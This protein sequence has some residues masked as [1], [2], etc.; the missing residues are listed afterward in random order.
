MEEFR[1]LNNEIGEYLE[2]S[3]RKALKVLGYSVDNHRVFERGIDVLAVSKDEQII[4]AIECLNWCQWSYVNAERLRS[5]VN[6]FTKYPKAT[7]IL[8]SSFDVLTRRQKVTLKKLGILILELDEQLLS[9]EK[10][11]IA[12]ILEVVY[13][14][15]IHIRSYFSSLLP[16]DTC[17][18][19]L[20][21]VLVL[22]GYPD[23]VQKEEETIEVDA[24]ALQI[25]QAEEEK[26]NSIASSSDSLVLSCSS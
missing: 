1:E 18:D 22:N 23:L 9:S 8:L 14:G 12:K 16:L 20:N 7:R 6:N 5:L 25:I 15:V 4:L 26:S 2:E 3:T 11:E 19:M 13:E 21:V 24:N 10:R 17:V